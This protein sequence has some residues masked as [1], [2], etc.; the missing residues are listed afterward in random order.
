[1]VEVSFVSKTG[2]DPRGW[3]SP[4]RLFVNSEVEVGTALSSVSKSCTS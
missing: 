3:E 1:M 4:I 2:F